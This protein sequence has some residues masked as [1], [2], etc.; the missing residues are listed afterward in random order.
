MGEE[1]EALMKRKTF[2]P[3][4]IIGELREAEV[5]LSQGQKVGALSRKLEVTEQT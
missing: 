4:Q 3:E 1:T 5:L 2:T